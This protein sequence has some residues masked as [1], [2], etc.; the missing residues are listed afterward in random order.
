V[1]WDI[2]RFMCLSCCTA[3]LNFLAITKKYPFILE[4]PIGRLSTAGVSFM[5]VLALACYYPIS[6]NYA[7]GETPFSINKQK[8]LLQIPGTII[9][10]WLGWLYPAAGS[11]TSAPMMKKG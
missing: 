3:F 11:P 9:K 5:L 8:A 2:D 4:K 1:A 7:E 6:E 10:T